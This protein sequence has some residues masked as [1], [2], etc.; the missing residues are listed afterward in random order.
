VKRLFY[1]IIMMSCC[2]SGWADTD[3]KRYQSFIHETRCMVCENQSVAESNSDFAQNMKI[4]IQEAIQAG[5]TDAEIKAALVARFGDSV[6]YA[7][8]F[9]ANTI[10]LWGA[11]L[12]FMLIGLLVVRNIISNRGHGKR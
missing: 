5:Q 1:T 6:F 4:W 12:I 10:L 2:L 3:Q 7:P 9:Q 11:P 8:P